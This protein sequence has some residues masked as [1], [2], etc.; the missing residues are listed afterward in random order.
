MSRYQLKVMEIHT[1]AK[2]YQ[3][4]HKLFFLLCEI[5]RSLGYNIYGNYEI[6]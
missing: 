6:I 2:I 1:V 5:K 3:K 4:A